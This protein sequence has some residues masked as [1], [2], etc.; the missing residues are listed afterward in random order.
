MKRRPLYLVLALWLLGTPVLVVGDELQICEGGN[1]SVDAPNT[2]IG[3]EICG[4]LVE[5]VGKMSACGLTQTK[6]ISVEV[7]PGL[8]HPIG[9]CLAYYDC[10]L[11]VIKVSNPAEFDQYLAT[12]EPYSV[13]PT[14]VLLRSLLTHELAHALTVQTAGEAQIDIVDQEY[15]AAALEMEFLDPEWREMLLDAAPVSLPPKEGLIDKWIYGLEPRKFATNAWQ[16]FDA[17]KDGC[18]LISLIATGRLSF[19]K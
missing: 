10:D 16:H 4:Y 2:E 15:I 18:N 13:L 9:T 12:D 5:A 14:A 8:S 1:F 3:L 17:Q 6:P 11:D 19:R 7:V